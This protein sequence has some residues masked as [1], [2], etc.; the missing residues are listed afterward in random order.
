MLKVLFVGGVFPVE[1]SLYRE[2]QANP[3]LDVVFA[4][5]SGCM[6]D[7]YAAVKPRPVTC[8]REVAQI[9][10][11]FNPDL[12]LYRSWCPESNWRV[13]KE[14]LWAQE[15][16]PIIGGASKSVQASV[17]C[18]GNKI[19]FQNKEYAAQTG[20]Y[21]LP[22]CVSRHWEC[23]APKDIPIML[24]TSIPTDSNAASNKERSLQI[25]AQPIA[26]K[27]P[28]LLYAYNGYW[29]Q[30]ESISYLRPCMKPSFAPVNMTS[31]IGR[32][33]IYLSPTSIFYEKGS[34]S[35]K[36]VQ[37]MACGCLVITNRYTGIED[38][39]GKDGDTI[40]YCD[41]PEETLEKVQYYLV[42]EEQREALAHR[43]ME[44]VH[45]KYGWLTNLSRLYS[46]VYRV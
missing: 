21:W 32:A 23:T 26:Q 45:N 15:I 41:T 43:A 25:L 28:N 36:T 27:M 11:Q 8:Q 33:K 40:V 12:V 39:V 46:E 37:A 2:A 14:I 35:H 44:F 4:C 17:G 3:D 38:I 42:H 31:F 5:G 20:Q 22:Y 16:F 9:I 29:G 10:G 19:A 30:L 1:Y 18:V 13:G 24:A 34:I 7:A 6:P